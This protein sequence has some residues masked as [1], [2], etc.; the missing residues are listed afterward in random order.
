[1]RDLSPA[2]KVQVCHWDENLGKYR[3]IWIPDLTAHMADERFQDDREPAPDGTCDFTVVE[4][5]YRVMS[6]DE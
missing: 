3:L 6:E 2:G 4:A 5:S 1:M